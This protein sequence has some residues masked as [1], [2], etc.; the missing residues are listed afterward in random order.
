MKSLTEC[1]EKSTMEHKKLKKFK[2]AALT[3]LYE[4]E[5]FVM[6]TSENQIQPKMYCKSAQNLIEL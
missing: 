5:S 3:L 4:S 6:T 1:S 2:L